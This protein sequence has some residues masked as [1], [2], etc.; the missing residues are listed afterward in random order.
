ME[1]RTGAIL[2]SAGYDHTIRFWNIANGCFVRTLQH[3]ESQ[4]NAL[5]ISPD[6]HL[7]AAAGY[8][9]IRIYDAQQG[10]T[11]AQPIVNYEGFSKN[12]TSIGFN[13]DM[14][15][16]YTGSEDFSAR[17]WDLRTRTLDCQRIYQ[18]NTPVNSVCLHPN[19]AELFIGDQSVS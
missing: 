5:A 17:I 2:A 4:V 19:Q 9:H 18:V 13:K 12:V 11:N 10:S 15:W 1:D 16:M 3:T 14:R 7:I 8:Q 6:R